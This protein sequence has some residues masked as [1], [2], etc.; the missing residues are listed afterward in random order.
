[1]NDITNKELRLETIGAMFITLFIAAV[2]GAV[3]YGQM[4]EKVEGKADKEVVAAVKQQ[5]ND[6]EKKV[7][8]NTEKV[9]EARDAA[10]VNQAILKRLEAQVAGDE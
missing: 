6:L 8:N 9:E 1:M 3:A 7:D 5:L 4:S 10:L 2:G